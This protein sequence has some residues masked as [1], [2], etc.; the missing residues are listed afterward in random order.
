MCRLFGFRSVINSQVHSSLVHAENALKDQSVR[1]PDGWGVAYY[2]ENNPHLIKSQNSA[3]D[4]HLFQKVSGIVSSQT[5][6]A[7]IRKATQGNLNILNAH[8][9]QYG[10]WVFAHNGNIKNFATHR[11]FFLSKIDSS[12]KRFILGETDSEILF[13]YLLTKLK[14]KFPLSETSIHLPTCLTLLEEALLEITEVIGDLSLSKKGAPPSENFLT[15][16]LTSGP[17]LIAFEGGQPLHECTYKT[18]CPD[19]DSCPSFSKSCENEVSKDSSVNHLIISSELIKGANVWKE[20]P[21]GSFVAIGTD[22]KVHRKM[23][24]LKFL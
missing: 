3:V 22:M 9:F 16:I 13:Y 14:S 23:S 8:P 12:L 18:R 15:F 21:S 10:P 6:V 19:R 4:D 24:S 5:V 17:T 20:I 2:I 7:H 1:H 11:D